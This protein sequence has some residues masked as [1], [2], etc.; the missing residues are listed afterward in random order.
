M[1][2]TH[3]PKTQASASPY[4]TD[5]TRLG[6]KSSCVTPTRYIGGRENVKSVMAQR[7]VISTKPE[8]AQ[9]LR[10]RGELPRTCPG[11]CRHEV[12]TPIDFCYFSRLPMSAGVAKKRSHAARRELGPK[13]TFRGDSLWVELPESARHRKQP[14]DLSTRPPS[15]AARTSSDLVETTDV[16]GVQ[17]L[18]MLSQLSEPL[19]L[20]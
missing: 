16:G 3:S 5:N 12:F 15:S 19:H 8:R 11:P 18:E 14:R 2:Q 6:I 10:A 9:R 17:P 20:Q 7:S 1:S 4:N 13:Q